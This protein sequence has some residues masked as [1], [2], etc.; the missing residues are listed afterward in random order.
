[1]GL[2]GTAG[3]DAHSR[4]EYAHAWIEI[5]PFA[6]RDEFVQNLRTAT[7]GGDLSPFFVH[8]FSI[9]RQATQEDG[10][11]ADVR[12]AA[13]GSMAATASRAQET[14]LSG[15]DHGRL[16]EYETWGLSCG[17]YRLSSF[18]VYVSLRSIAGV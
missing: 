4:P 7:I 12:A 8:F 14:G 3:S 18:V 9:D 5:E 2:P 6:T 15:H 17:G 16:R 13:R 1:M 11:L 10:A